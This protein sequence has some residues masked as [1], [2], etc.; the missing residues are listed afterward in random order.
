MRVRS[1]VPGLT[2]SEVKVNPGLCIRLSQR[3]TN[4]G[5]SLGS[6]SQLEITVGLL[7]SY[8][9]RHMIQWA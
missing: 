1:P 9:L 6:L 2:E 4:C 5:I 3:I 7:V 8:N